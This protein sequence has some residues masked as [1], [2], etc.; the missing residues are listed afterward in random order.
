[1]WV[2]VATQQQLMLKQVIC[3]HIKT[4]KYMWVFVTTQQQFMLEQVPT[5]TTRGRSGVVVNTLN[6]KT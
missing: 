4:N 6:L 2:Y 3:Q 1:M 5:V